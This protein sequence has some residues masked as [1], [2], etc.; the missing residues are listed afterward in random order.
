M[1][2][3]LPSNTVRSLAG[4]Q[5]SKCRE[6]AKPACS[7]A[8]VPQLES[9]HAATTEPVR[10]GACAPPLER[11]PRAETRDPTCYNEDPVCHN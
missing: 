10:P 2:K 1:V 4:K 11:S 5:D 9:L 8:H 3:N 7:R 6:A